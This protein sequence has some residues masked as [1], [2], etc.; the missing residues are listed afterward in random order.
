MDLISTNLLK[1]PLFPIHQ[2]LGAA[3]VEFA[4]WAMPIQYK[5][6]LKEHLAVR[7]GVG[8]FDVSH[9]GEIEAVGKD[10]IPMAQKVT[11]NDVS[12]LADGQAQYSAFLSPNGTFIDDIVLYRIT[13]EHILICVNA[14]NKDEDFKWLMEQKEGAV[15]FFDN[16]DHYTQLAIQGPQA[17]ATL[18][19]LTDVD[20]SEL[21]FYW[22]KRGQVD[23]SEAFISRT[24]YTG[25]DGFEIYFPPAHAESVWWQLLKTGRDFGI[26]PAGLAA[27]NTLRLEMRYLLYGKDIDDTITPWEADVGWIVKLNKGDFIGKEALESQKE[28]G[29]QRKLIG[30]EMV[31]RGIARD[32]FQSYWNGEAVGEVCSGSFSPS[33]RKGIGLVYLPNLGAQPGRSFQIEVRGK[34]L[35]ARVVKT[36]FYRRA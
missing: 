1:T 34:R 13:A 10:V 3:I 24:G 14:A 26:V 8:V 6:A 30:F 27:R 4:G 16:S 31:E 20:L 29:I 28:V 12:R 5:S 25:E 33:L 23:G 15:E 19:P 32:H 18:Q 2:E 17:E 11:S 21:P 7:Q 22:F 36:P 35:K 9:M